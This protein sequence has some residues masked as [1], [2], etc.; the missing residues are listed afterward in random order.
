[1]RQFSTNVQAALA[2]DFVEYF[3]LVELNLNNNYYMTSHSTDLIIDEQVYTGNGAIFSY[4][5]PSKNSVIDRESYKLAFIDPNNNL[6]QEA[7]QGIIGKNIKVRA[8]FIHDTLGPLTNEYDLVYV[9]TGFVD[10][11]SI[12][13]DFESKILTIEGSSPMA[14]LDAVRPYF[15]TKYGVTQYDTSDSCFDRVH[16][17]YDLQ[18]KW[19]KT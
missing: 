16:D 6:L 17:G 4:E 8:G 11:P 2:Q 12:K 14:D 9:Y 3:F 15:T 5:P 19:G 10:A 1:M 18:L 7:L 13:N